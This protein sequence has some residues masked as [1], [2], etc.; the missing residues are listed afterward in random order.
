MNMNQLKFENRIEMSLDQIQ[1]ELLKL[2]KTKSETE[3]ETL[4][5]ERVREFYEREKETEKEK[6]TLG[7]G[8]VFRKKLMKY[9]YGRELSDS[10]M[11]IL[12]TGLEKEVGSIV[13]IVKN[14]ISRIV[15][16]GRQGVTYKDST[17]EEKN[18]G[19]DGQEIIKKIIKFTTFADKSQPEE[20]DYEE[21]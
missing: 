18:F 12:E 1:A 9:L 5:E 2:F 8:I 10:E 13:N 21:R 14:I 20:K 4:F 3:G 6:A 17:G 11:Q 15:S 16:E 19:K 7:G